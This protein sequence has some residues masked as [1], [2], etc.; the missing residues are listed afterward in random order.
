MLVFAHARRV[1]A[2]GSGLMPFDRSTLAGIADL[3]EI[4]TLLPAAVAVALA[5]IA[6]RRLRD[7]LAWTV[8]VAGCVVLTAALKAAFASDD[9]LG[10]QFRAVGFPSGHAALSVG[11][12]GVLALATLNAAAP[13]WAT[14]LFSAA[15]AAL[16]GIIVYAVWRL[17][18]H[19]PL[20]LVG[21]G[22]VG[23]ATMLIYQTVATRVALPLRA[24]ALTIA[25]AAAIV[26]LLLGSRLQYEPVSATMTLRMVA[27]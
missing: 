14:R 7:A 20:D 25:A 9:F 24:G 22:A 12:Y 1:R 8:A 18:W 6:T 15:L 4:P 26:V 21:G 13:V 2:L 27:R 3:A 17:H 10:G 19:T 16:G 5:L 23:L 11:F